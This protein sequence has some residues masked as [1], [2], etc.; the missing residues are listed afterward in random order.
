MRE[1][2]STSLPIGSWDEVLEYV[3]DKVIA[4]KTKVKTRPSVR[5][6]AQESK[7]AGCQESKGSKDSNSFNSQR[8]NLE[9]KQTQNPDRDSTPFPSSHLFS[10]QPLSPSPRSVAVSA[11]VK[12]F[13]LNRDQCCQH[14]DLQSKRKCASKW[15]FAGGSYSACLGW[16]GQR[17]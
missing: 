15:E 6:E 11:A 7:M 10:S 5:N 9:Q 17:D 4:Q 3:S 2:L 1:L 13:I 14:I 8:H 12:K 16:W